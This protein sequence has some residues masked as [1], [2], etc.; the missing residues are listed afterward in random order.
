[1]RNLKFYFYFLVLGCL[2]QSSYSQNK[3]AEIDSF[4]HYI[5]T[6]LFSSSPIYGSN[7]RVTVG[8]LGQLKTRWMYGVE[9]GY[10][11]YNFLGSES[12]KR[13]G[14]DKGYT[15]FELRPSIHY[16]IN[17]NGKA[18]PYIAA[19]FFYIN[20]IDTF[21]NDEESLRN[22]RYINNGDN[23]P[24]IAYDKANFKR[25]KYGVN[26]NFGFF[27]NIAK[28]FGVNNNI[29]L[30]VR[31]RNIEYKNVVNP[32]EITRPDSETLFT[33]IHLLETGNKLGLNFSFS[34]KVFY[35]IK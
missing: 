15:L 1:M 20:H 9:L 5:L 8:Y 32:S 17:P 35:R 28:R 31:N 12:K 14:I 27:L 23:N 24:T 34:I 30:G 11:K 2:T 4:S 33:P 13:K 25:Q 26:F 6:N 3:T 29:G 16:I 21:I 7:P 18:K 22:R 19:E 10:A